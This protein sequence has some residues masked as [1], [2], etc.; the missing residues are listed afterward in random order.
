MTGGGP[1][2]KGTGVL[3]K[4]ETHLTLNVDDEPLTCVV[5]GTGKILED[6]ERYASVLMDS[7]SD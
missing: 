6:P 4:E 1:Q 3:F 7:T 2:L 5:R